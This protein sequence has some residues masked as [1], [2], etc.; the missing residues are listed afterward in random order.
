MDIKFSGKYKVQINIDTSIF[1]SKF[2]DCLTSNLENKRANVTVENETINYETPFVVTLIS[3]KMNLFFRLSW[4]GKG[5]VWWKHDNQMIKYYYRMNLTP[6]F[7]SSLLLALIILGLMLFTASF[8]PYYLFRN[9]IF[10]YLIICFFG[11]ALSKARMS[12]LIKDCISENL[13]K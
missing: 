9:S 8:E 11:L 13:V 10:L 6:I 1:N 3:T 5:K 12:N 2:V 7:V 4:F